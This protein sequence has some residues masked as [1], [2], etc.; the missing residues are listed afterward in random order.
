MEGSIILIYKILSLLIIR[1]LYL[2][3]GMI[4]LEY[5]RVGQSMN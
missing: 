2:I 5:V 4:A 1:T 3:I